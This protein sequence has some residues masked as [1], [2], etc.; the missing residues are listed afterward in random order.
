ME[1]H[2]RLPL[3]QARALWRPMYGVSVDKKAFKKAVEE[4]V[5]EVR[6]G[7]GWVNPLAVLEVPTVQVRGGLSQEQVSQTQAEPPSTVDVQSVL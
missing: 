1:R 3:K 6:Q 4:K 2:R 7:W 5:Q